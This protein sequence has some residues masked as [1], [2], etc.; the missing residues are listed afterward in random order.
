MQSAL[1]PGAN[2]GLFGIKCAEGFPA[3]G[4]APLSSKVRM[5]AFPHVAA[6]HVHV[7][8]CVSINTVSHH[9]LG[10]PPAHDVKTPKGAC[11]SARR[12][13][14]VTVKYS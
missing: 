2:Y 9:A 10:K 14:I 1:E 8:E 13:E 5:C 3:R 7:I 6:L 11:R 4:V 12:R